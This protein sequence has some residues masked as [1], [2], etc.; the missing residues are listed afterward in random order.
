VPRFGTKL[1]LLGVALSALWM[2]T[3][4]GYEAGSDVRAA[5]LLV[6]M[7]VA[8]F[9][10][11]YRRGRQQAF[12]LG[13]VGALLL[14]AIQPNW[15]FVPTVR[16]AN[17]I[18]ERWASQTPIDPPPANATTRHSGLLYGRQARV[19]SAIEATFWLACA[20]PLSTVIGYIGAYIYD[21]SRTSDPSCRVDHDA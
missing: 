16:W 11:V 12:W 21:Q 7:F 10:A 6:I 2:S 1:L 14:L 15:R 20:L 9:E 8:A 19:S 3:L 5:I 4:G 18:A 17:R 13:F